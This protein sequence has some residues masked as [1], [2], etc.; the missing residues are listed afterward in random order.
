MISSFYLQAQKKRHYRRKAA[1][2]QISGRNRKRK[3]QPTHSKDRLFFRIL[4]SPFLSFF[5]IV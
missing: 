4:L 1:M 2:P 3:I 5:G